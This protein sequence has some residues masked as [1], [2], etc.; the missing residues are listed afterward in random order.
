MNIKNKIL[1]INN[2]VEVTQKNLFEK[3]EVKH[4]SISW[5]Q[6]PSGAFNLKQNFPCISSKEPFITHLTK[7]KK[8]CVEFST[9]SFFLLPPKSKNQKH[10]K[11]SRNPYCA[12]FNV[13]SNYVFSRFL[14]FI[15]T[16]PKEA[17]YI[18]YVEIMIRGFSL[19]LPTHVP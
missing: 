3:I 4:F 16:R 12:R 15:F 2:S 19:H 17:K 13:K 6:I 10:V 7:F 11:Y 14:N 1:Y 9:F 18:I 5:L 8:D